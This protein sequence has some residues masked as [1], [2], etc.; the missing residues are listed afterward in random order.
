MSLSDNSP[1]GAGLAPGAGFLLKSFLSP[2]RPPVPGTDGAGFFSSLMIRL[3]LCLALFPP[4][5][6]AAGNSILPNT[7]NPF[8]VSPLA[9]IS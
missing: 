6:P 4:R 2:G 1:L 8:K 3:R 5:S 7:V 9:S